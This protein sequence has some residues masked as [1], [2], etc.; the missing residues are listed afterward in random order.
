MILY[1]IYRLVRKKEEEIWCGRRDSNI[2]TYLKRWAFLRHRRYTED[3]RSDTLTQ[4]GA[5]YQIK[6][7]TI[8]DTKNH[9]QNSFLNSPLFSLFAAAKGLS[10][11]KEPVAPWLIIKSYRTIS[12]TQILGKKISF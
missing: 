2:L 6:T 10:A 1:K 3:E 4:F 9:F 12:K 8:L 7:Q 11:T 5:S